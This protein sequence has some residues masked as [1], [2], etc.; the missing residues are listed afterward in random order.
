MDAKTINLPLRFRLTGEEGVFHKLS[1][2][3]RLLQIIKERKF[4]R[5][6]LIITT[7]ITNVLLIMIGAEGADLILESNEVFA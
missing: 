5:A 2:Y 1:I 3:D 6:Y 4:N 7:G